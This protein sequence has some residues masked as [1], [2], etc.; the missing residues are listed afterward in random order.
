MELQPLRAPCRAQ[1]YVNH[2]EED[3][4]DDDDDDGN[5]ILGQDADGKIIKSVAGVEVDSSFLLR[6][7]ENK[8]AFRLRQTEIRA[9]SAADEGK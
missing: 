2:D 4:D 1:F 9:S 7:R 3:S 5:D 8:K 6:A